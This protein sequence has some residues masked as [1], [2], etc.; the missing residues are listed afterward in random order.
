MSNTEQGTVFGKLGRDFVGSVITKWTRKISVPHRSSKHILLKFHSLYLFPSFSFLFS[1]HKSA[2]IKQRSMDGLYWDT[3]PEDPIADAESSEDEV[4]ESHNGILEI[5]CKK[6]RQSKK[7]LCEQCKQKVKRLM[8]LD[9]LPQGFKLENLKL[10]K[11]RPSNHSPASEQ[12]E[13]CASRESDERDTESI[14]SSDE[15]DAN[16]NSSS[17]DTYVSERQQ[18]SAPD[19]SNRPGL[20]LSRAPARRET[21]N[22]RTISR[23]SPHRNRVPVRRQV[24]N[25]RRAARPRQSTSPVIPMRN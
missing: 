24:S 11:G 2:L 4:I 6:C 7:R 13:V 22:Q 3:F 12:L 21:A 18:S 8:L 15:S 10:R 16:Y 5:L 9:A 17:D 23:P 20:G 1:S 14:T 25:Q 19:R